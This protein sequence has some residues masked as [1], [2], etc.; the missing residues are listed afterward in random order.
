[1]RQRKEDSTGRGGGGGC[2]VRLL[3][4]DLARILQSL[5]RIL[6]FGRWLALNE[7]R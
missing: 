1:M 7:R 2:G 4:G 5:A 6:D 3:E